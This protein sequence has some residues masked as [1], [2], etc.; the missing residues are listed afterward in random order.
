MAKPFLVRLPESLHD[1]IAREAAKEGVSMNQI[2]LMR[3]SKESKAKDHQRTK[4]SPKD[5]K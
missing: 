5:G 2:M 3:L 1:E 4:K